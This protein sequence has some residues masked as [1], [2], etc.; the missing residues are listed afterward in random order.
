[1]G[2][3]GLLAGD[4]VIR[5][6]HWD[7]A[8]AAKKPEEVSWYQPLPEKSLEL[9]GKTGVDKDAPI[10]DVGAGASRLV[11]NLLDQGY[12]DISVLDVSPVALRHAQ[13]RVGERAEQVRWTESDVLLFEPERRFALWHDRATFHFLTD[14]ADRDRYLDVV[15][16]SLQ[17]GG[18]FV[19][20]TFGP[21]GPRKC[22][23]LE[24]RRYS[25]DELGRLLTG[26]FE[27][28][29]HGTEQHSTPGDATQQFLYSW[30]QYSQT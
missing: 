20:A 4:P 21:Q 9:V 12:S 26:H 15:R 27:L 22:S 24:V 5:K 10:I 25:I 17:P 18:H 6:Q 28:R 30:W 19:L 23:G 3:R 8:Y 7:A 16:R 14:S 29:W 2:R 11:D 1:M 13:D